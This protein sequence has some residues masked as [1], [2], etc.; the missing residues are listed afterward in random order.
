MNQTTYIYGLQDPNTNEIR[1]VG[2]SN[3]PKRRLIQHVWEATPY[4]TLVGSKYQ[5]GPKQEWLAGL[6]ISNQ[7]PVL[8]ILEKCYLIQWKEREA[9]WFT[10]LSNLG[11][12]L[13]N[14]PEKI[15]IGK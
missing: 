4:V 11:N 5:R 9:F 6:I 13:V 8:V 10:C 3:S 2:K 12:N 14:S 15:G 7:K 1:Y